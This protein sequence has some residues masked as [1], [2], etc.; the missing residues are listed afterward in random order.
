MFKLR[1]FVATNTAAINNVWNKVTVN[2]YL[3]YGNSTYCLY[4]HYVPPHL[5]ENILGYCSEINQRKK[6]FS[7]K[8]F[9]R[10]QLN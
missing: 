8:R 10:F 2:V 5:P 7:W 4:K 1:Y 3:V 6:V 9:Y